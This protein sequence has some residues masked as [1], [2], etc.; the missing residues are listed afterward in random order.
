MVNLFPKTQINAIS[1]VPT[2]D[3]DGMESVFYIVAVR[4][5]T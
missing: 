5:S 2:G 1:S 4:I 3:I